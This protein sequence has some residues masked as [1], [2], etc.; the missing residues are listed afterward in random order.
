VR[1]A[2]GGDLT[3]DPD[4]SDFLVPAPAFLHT[5][6]QVLWSDPAPGRWQLIVWG[7]GFSGDSFQEPYSGTITLDRDPVDQTPWTATAAPGDTVVKTFT[8]TDAGP[9]D[10]SA[11]AQSQQ[12]WNGMLQSQDVALAPFHVT[13]DSS[14][15]G[16]DPVLTF[17]VP[18]KVSLLTAS[19][20]WSSDPG[21]LVDLCLVDPTG[22]DRATSLAATDLGNYDI[23]ADPM[24]GPWQI[25]IGYGEPALPAPSA[26]VTVTVDCVV[27]VPVD[28]F[29]S[30]ANEQDPVSVSG[31]GGT[32]TITAEIKVPADAQ[33]GD[34]IEGV[35][36]F[37]STIDGVTAAGGDHL[38]TVPVTIT[39][40][41]Q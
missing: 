16:F 30:S 18:Q 36:D 38:G 29:T 34:V 10:M 4:Y 3:A 24:A 25:D 33:D 27:P 39:V 5:R 22:T 12:V 14:S 21:T 15:T 7:P 2:K 20:L 32:G 40:Q 28:G 37:Y 35:V 11:Y 19:A 13:L 26:E 8:V 6:E 17:P 1:D 23:V 41:S 9:A 31:R